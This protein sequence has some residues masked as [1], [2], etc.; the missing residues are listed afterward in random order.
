M[1]RCDDDLIDFNLVIEP[2]PED[3]RADRGTP[4]D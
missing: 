3:R 2:G 4:T 1:D